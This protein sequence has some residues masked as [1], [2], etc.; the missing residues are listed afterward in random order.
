MAEFQIRVA[1]PA[2]AKGIAP[3]LAELLKRPKLE[4]GI[5]EGLNTNLLRVLQTPGTTMLVAEADDGRLL[6]FVSLWTRW[7]IL[8]QNPSGL[9][10]RIVVRPSYR[11]KTVSSA[12]LEQAL[13]AC[14]AMGCGSVE[15]IL[16]PESTVDIGALQGFGFE[17]QG[18]RYYLEIL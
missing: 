10:D 6:G 3:I 15:L 7:G 2:D 1:A 5:I 14:Q 17:E 4:P 11:D 16:T 12:L 18:K 9:I 13:G 8:D